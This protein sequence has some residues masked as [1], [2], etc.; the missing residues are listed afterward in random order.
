[1][2]KDPILFFPFSKIT[3]FFNTWNNPSFFSRKYFL[4]LIF[5]TFLLISKI[6]SYTL[7]D[8]LNE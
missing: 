8:F 6:D 4:P 5:Q 7:H 3:I 1:M 2:I